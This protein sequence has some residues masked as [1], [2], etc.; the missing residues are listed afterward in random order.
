MKAGSRI[1]FATAH[2]QYRGWGLVEICTNGVLYR[3][4][5]LSARAGGAGSGVTSP[6]SFSNLGDAQFLLVWYDTSHQGIV[7]G[8]PHIAIVTSPWAAGSSACHLRNFSCSR[9]FVGSPL[10]Q[11]DLPKRFKIADISRQQRAPNHQ[12]PAGIPGPC[13]TQSSARGIYSRS[14]LTPVGPS[15]RSGFASAP[16]GAAH[17]TLLPDANLPQVSSARQVLSLYLD[18]LVEG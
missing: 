6:L 17:V 11:L 9:V 13:T 14:L 18:T 3:R 7:D 2:G 4:Y 8:R 15:E 16:P 1:Q 5:S 12:R 10:F